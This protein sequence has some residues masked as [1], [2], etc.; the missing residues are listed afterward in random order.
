MALD[1]GDIQGNVLHSFGTSLAAHFMLRLRSAAAGVALLKD[2][3]P[4]VTPAFQ[5][6]PEPGLNLWLTYSGLRLLGA[7]RDSRRVPRGV[8]EEDFA[9]H[10][11]TLGDI[12]GSDP[13]TWEQDL[14]KG[15]W[16]LIVA[17]HAGRGLRAGQAGMESPAEAVAATCGCRRP[18]PCPTWS[19]TSGSP[20]GRPSHRSRVCPTARSVRGGGVPLRNG[21]WRPVKAGEFILGY[22]DEDGP[23][24]PKKDAGSSATAPYVVWRKLAQD[25]PAFRE[26]LEA[27]VRNG[28]DLD[29]SSWW[30]RRS[31]A[32]GGTV[33]HRV[34]PADR[35]PAT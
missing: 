34:G 28:P 10:A 11:R 22:P 24:D 30:P 13:D 31:W 9:D 23:V 35:N 2:V 17:V 25:V 7:G 4:D 29:R 8:S 18:G 32:A 6:R 26:A 5:E 3:A 1:L 21:E 16:H 19:S 12:G 27:A 20:T 14:G 15:R 33:S